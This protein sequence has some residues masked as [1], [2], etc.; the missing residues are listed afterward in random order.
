MK[1][2]NDRTSSAV[3]WFAAVVGL[4]WVGQGMAFGGNG[5]DGADE[6]ALMT[7]IVVEPQKSAT[8]PEMMTSLAGERVVYFG[9]TH[10]AF[11][12]HLLQL[13]VLKAM[14][15]QPG[16]LALGVEWI[17]APFQDAVD[18]YIRGEID[19]GEFLRATEYYERWR[20]DY[21]LYRPIVQFARD[22]GIPIIALNAPRE[23][24][25]EISRVGINGLPEEM[26]QR[27]PDDYDFSDKAY[28]ASLHEMFR[29]HPSEDAAFQRFL[30]VQLTWDETMAE[31]VAAWL[32]GGAQRRMLVLAGKGH[33]SGRS[34]IP[35]RVTRRTGIE[36]K[37]VGTFS[38]SSRLFNEADFMV[39]AN[40]QELPPA[41][42]MRVLLDERDGHIYIKGFTEESP[43]EVA[44]LRKDDR[45]T[46]INGVAVADY[47]DLKL[48][49][50]DQRPG[51]EI[52]VSVERKRFFGGTQPQTARFTLVAAS[53]SPH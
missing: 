33:V 39:L 17:Q 50:L 23:V 2:S 6:V 32:D 53:R 40:E 41:G 36:G 11:G 35:N 45:I 19:E 10:T 12:D 9:E 43:A 22:R 28:E 5:S 4:V 27:L 48:Q 14:A 25:Q 8:L 37:T 49:M 16:Q 1:N 46:A 26:R 3:R 15:A 29:M 30:E 44:G 47:I 52:E 13:E 31:N 51:S 34:G 24:T 38:P 20:F 7:P 21:R 18:R 42:I